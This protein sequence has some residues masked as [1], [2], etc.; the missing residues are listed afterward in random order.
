MIV[1]TTATVDGRPI[2][3]YLG[4]ASGETIMGANVLKDISASVRDIVGG[5]SGSYENII[6][7][8]RETALAELIERAEAAGANAIVGVDIDYEAIDRRS[9]EGGSSSSMLMVSASGTLVRVA[10]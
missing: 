2:Q 10:E 3:E 9:G 8:A 6:S 1:T 7:K 5:R 4:V